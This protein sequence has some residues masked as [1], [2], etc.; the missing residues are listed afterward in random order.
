MECIYVWQ[1]ETSHL[2]APIR[3]LFNSGVGMGAKDAYLWRRV[4]C[5]F[6][7]W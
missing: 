7:L 2:I 1:P 3:L 4:A 5:G 6:G